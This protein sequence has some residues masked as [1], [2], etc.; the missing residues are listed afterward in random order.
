MKLER[1]LEAGADGIE[2]DPAD[3]VVA[4]DLFLARGELESAASALDRAYGLAPDD[5]DI[6]EQRRDVLERLALTEHDLV[7]RYIPAGTFLMGSTTG[8]PDERP[9]HAVGLDAFWIT[10]VPITWAAYCERMGWE[11]PPSGTPPQLE[12]DDD[13]MRGF[14]LNEANKIRRSYCGSDDE[15]SDEDSEDDPFSEHGG[16]AYGR[17]LEYD[18]KPM[19]AVGWADAEVL[20]ERLTTATARFALP[21]ESQW[22]KAARG[23]LIGKPYSWGDAAPTRECCDFGHFGQ[24]MI[25]D[26]RSL[27]SNG[28]GL[29]GMCGG[30]W[31]WTATLYDALAYARKLAGRIADDELQGR[32]D[33]RLLALNHHASRAGVDPDLLEQP[34]LRVL[35]GG[36]WA[37][38]AAAVT[39]SVRMAR[40]GW[41]WQ[42][43][44]WSAS[45]TPNV[46]FRLIRMRT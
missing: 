28:Y 46:G 11:P 22:E 5:R 20:A 13:R 21:S 33:E 6:A 45:D 10:D 44:L 18:R 19:V 17:P 31:E 40:E 1:V 34:H 32:P 27:P 26:P 30:V 4:A 14:H 29:H 23:G 37:D 3:F 8:D 12:D 25:A 7:F 9:V 16:H 42:S 38:G 15:D 2:G 41:G 35:R 43:G 39:L 36:S 24:F